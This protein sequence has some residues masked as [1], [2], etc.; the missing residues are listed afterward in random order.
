MVNSGQKGINGVVYKLT[1][2]NTHLTYIGSTQNFTRR[3]AQHRSD[4][5]SCCSRKLY[6]KGNDNVSVIFLFKQKFLNRTCMERLE[7]KMIRKE[8][9]TNRKHCVNHASKKNPIL[10]KYLS[11]INSKIENT[12]YRTNNRN[13]WHTY[14]KD[15]HTSNNHIF[16]RCNACNK[17]VR[18]MSL[19][20]HNKGRRHRRNINKL[21]ECGKNPI[22]YKV[23]IDG[24]NVSIVAKL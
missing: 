14:F 22:E 3:M 6:T 7:K 1:N 2:T 16:H 21:K 12:L 9:R 8:Y 15:L 5:N 24:D 18:I 19:K 4:Q 13:Y 20:A 10:Q 23:H 17:T 11:H